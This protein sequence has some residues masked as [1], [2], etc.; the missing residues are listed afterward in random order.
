MHVVAIGD[1]LVVHDCGGDAGE[2]VGPAH[3]VEE[4]TL[5]FFRVTADDAVGVLAKDLH[6]ALVALAHA[7]A[8]E[9]VLVAALLLAHLAVPPQLLEPLGFDPVR[10]RLW[11]QEIVLPH[12]FLP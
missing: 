5:E 1:V 8:L 12:S 6:L 2:A 11:R 9:A 4:S 7:V 3:M 10:D